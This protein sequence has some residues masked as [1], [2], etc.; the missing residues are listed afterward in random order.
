MGA[1]LGSPAWR[2]LKARC[3]DGLSHSGE[4]WAGL[5][6]RCQ[7]AHLRNLEAGVRTIEHRLSPPVGQKGT[8]KAPG[9]YRSQREWHTKSRRLPVLQDRLAAARADREAGIVH[10][11]RGGKR[12]ARARQHLEAAQLTE[13]E[14]LTPAQPL[15]TVV[16]P[17]RDAGEEHRL[18]QAVG[19]LLRPTRQRMT[20]GPAPD[21]SGAGPF[22]SYCRRLTP[23]TPHAPAA[24]APPGD[25]SPN[26]P[27]GTS[28]P[29]ARCAGGVRRAGCPRRPRGPGG[30][31]G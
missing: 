14:W 8:K 15:G 10:V 12:L 20:K 21:R 31:S 25:A 26:P 24:P 18:G 30:R 3:R 29:G 4:A 23:R 16:D 19:C 17:Q 5:A 27:P 13:G 6:R 22:L 9:G 1:Y 28:P 2:D 11:V 7:L